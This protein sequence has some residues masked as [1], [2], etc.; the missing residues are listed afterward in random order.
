VNKT[1][2]TDI[3]ALCPCIL[4]SNPQPPKD[5]GL[6]SKI[7]PIVF[8]KEDRHSPE[9][10]AAF[11]MLMA[12]RAGQLKV[13]GEFAANYIM[14]SHHILLKKRKEECDWKETAKIVITEFYKT[15]DLDAPYWIDYFLEEELHIVDDS[16]D[17]VRLLVRA[18]F[19]NLINETYNKYARIYDDMKDMKKTF[20]MRF[21]FCC[22]NDLIP[23]ISLINDKKTIVIFSNIMKEVRT[24]RS[25]IDSSEI[26]SLQELA[27]TIGLEYGQKWLNG[28]NTKVAYGNIAKFINFLD[29]EIEDKENAQESETAPAQAA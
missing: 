28:K 10:K 27:N 9:E 16:A 5:P 22:E 23:S 14:N 3:P 29:S 1:I 25:G 18:F 13:L 15:A 11:D 17:D 2:Y 26:A 20:H 19:I 7:I 24:P 4:T 21:N 8:T 6:R 12:Q